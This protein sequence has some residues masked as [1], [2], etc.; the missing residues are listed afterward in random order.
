MYEKNFA[1]ADE[2]WCNMLY[3]QKEKNR[4]IETKYSDIDCKEVI[5]LSSE[6]SKCKAC[7][8]FRN[9]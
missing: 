8:C 4:V 1:I 6:I 7:V 2:M 3:K 5:G 9:V